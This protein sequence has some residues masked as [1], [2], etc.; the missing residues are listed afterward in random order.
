MWI[1]CIPRMVAPGRY[2]RAHGTRPRVRR[3]I[4]TVDDAIDYFREASRLHKSESR[5]GIS[6]ARFVVAAGRLR[7]ER[8]LGITP[9]VRIPPARCGRAS[10]PGTERRRRLRGEAVARGCPG[11]P[12]GGRVPRGRRRPVCRVHRGSGAGA[13]ILRQQQGGDQGAGRCRWYSGSEFQNGRQRRWVHD[14]RCSDPVGN[15][16]WRTNACQDQGEQYQ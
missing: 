5:K 13:H 9:A 10:G 7:A 14:F 1:I 8:R 16:N 6:A 4:R 3:L 15:C 2:V 12:W 11:P